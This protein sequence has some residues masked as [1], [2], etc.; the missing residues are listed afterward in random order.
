MPSKTPKPRASA[1]ARAAFALAFAFLPLALGGCPSGAGRP[2]GPSEAPAEDARALELAT[3]LYERG[4]SLKTFAL[5]GEANYARGRDRRFHRFELIAAKPDAF[6]FTA[7]DPL[8]RPAFKLLSRDGEIRALDYLEAV[9]H[10]G[11]ARDFSLNDL[12]PTPFGP[13]AFLALLAGALPEKPVRAEAL[14]AFPAREATVSLNYW[15]PYDSV[16]YLVQVQGGPLWNMAEK[17]RARAFS[18]GSRYNPEFVAR[19]GGFRDREWESLNESLP[20][21]DSVTA[22]WKEKGE[23][24]EL[25]V[26]YQEIRLGFPLPEGLLELAPPEGYPVERL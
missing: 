4:E 16:P 20:F 5:R 6:L 25:V 7:F 14:E 24:R 3:G 11:D 13:E 10:V 26:R 12:L 15:G 18:K 8:G 22:Q 1:L 9:F 23:A 17:P 21:P 19:F 2:L